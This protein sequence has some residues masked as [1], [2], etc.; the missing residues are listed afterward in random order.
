MKINKN[1][2]TGKLKKY[3]NYL[4]I[5]LVIL[6]TLSLVRS[7]SKIKQAKEK[8]QEKEARIEKLRKENIEAEKRLEEV[9]SQAYIEKQLRD[10]LGFAKEGEIV[11]VLPDEEIIKSIAP[12]FETKEDI[13]LEP[14][15]KQWLNLFVN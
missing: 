8:I 10:S 15:W 9:I 11:V 1:S 5:F 13:L 12:H 6:L 14:N 3:I 4:F 2:L 7:I